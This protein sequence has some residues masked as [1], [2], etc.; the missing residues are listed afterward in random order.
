MCEKELSMIQSGIHASAEPLLES[1]D[2]DQHYRYVKK[3]IQE[4]RED[5]HASLRKELFGEDEG[6]LTLDKK[7]MQSL[8]RVLRKVE[9]HYR[10]CC[11]AP[12]PKE[13]E[14]SIRSRDDSEWLPWEMEAIEKVD[15][16]RQELKEKKQEGRQML[17]KA[18]EKLR[19][20]ER[21]S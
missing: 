6:D 9:R 20:G 12:I 15:A 16:W 4:L 11:T 14:G 7:Q 13:L 17:L 1:Q 5:N 3:L 19:K 2:F 10:E 8:F 21:V 18:L